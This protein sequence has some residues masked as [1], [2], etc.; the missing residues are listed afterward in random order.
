MPA[1]APAANVLALALAVPVHAGPG[2]EPA[3]HPIGGEAEHRR[4]ARTSDR[5]RSPR[6]RP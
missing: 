4:L 1:R 3:A 2:E 5:G 6:A